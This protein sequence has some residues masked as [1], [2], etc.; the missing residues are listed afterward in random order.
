[1]NKKKITRLMAVGM[2]LST[3]SSIL[4]IEAVKAVEDLNSHSS[5]V[6]DIKGSGKSD[7]SIKAIS[8]TFDNSNEG[9][10]YDDAW[11]YAS[12]V[13]NVKHN[14][15]LEALS[16]G[17]D[18]SQNSQT[19]WSEFKISNKLSEVKSLNGYNILT[20]DFIYDS[21]SMSS[22]GFKTKLFIK[23]INEENKN[24]DP[25]TDIKLSEAEKL[26]NGLSK[27]SVKI[28]FN[29]KDISFD[30][31]TLGIIGVNTNYK[32][33]LYIDNIV[34]DKA[35][36][37]EIYV[38]KTKEPNG[39]Q[40]KVKIDDLEMPEKVKLVDSKANE[41]TADLYAYLMAL[42]KSDKV[43]YGHQNDT[44]RKATYTEGTESDTKD[45][46]GSISGVVGIDTLSLTGDELTS[47]QK[48]DEKSYIQKC[49]EIGK[50]TA[51]QGGI[52]TL[53]AHMPNLAV[54]KDK[55]KN[56][57]GKYDYSGY[58]SSTTQGNV[59]DNMLPGGEL[60]EVYRGFLDIIAEYAHGLGDTPI[61]FRPL[62][63][64]NGSWFWWG[65]AF[66]DSQTYKSVFAYTVEY[67]RDVKGVHN[68]L[69]VYSPNGPFEDED[70]YLSRYPGDEFVDVIAFDMYHE[71]PSSAGTDD[72]WFESL[73]ETV[74]LVDSVAE[75]RGK[76]S[77]ASELGVKAN[78]G[79]L[80][81]SDN[82]NKQ[83]FK[84][85]SDILSES[86]MPYYMTWANFNTSDNFFAPF[87]V[88]ETKGHEMINDFIDY[89][90]DEKSIFANQIGDYTQAETKVDEAYS[91]GYI[92][93]PVSRQRILKPTTIKAKV[94]NIEGNVSFVIKDKEGKVLETISAQEVD[95]IWTGEITKDILN[96]IG[97]VNGTIELK[98][99]DI[100]L[101]YIK[102][103][104]NMKESEKEPR[105]VDDFEQY[106]G[107]DS[108]ISSEW[109]PN[110]G[111]G[112]AVK[113]KLSTEYKKDGEYGLEFAYKISTEKT[114]EGYTGIAKSVGSNWS[115]TDALQLWIKPDGNGQ[116]LIIQITS[117]GEEFEVNLQ[118]IA[119]TT[120][121]QLLKIDFSRFKGKKGGQ[122]DLSNIEKFAI[123]CNTIV[124]DGHEGAW[125]VNSSIYFDDIRAI[126]TKETPSNGG[127]SSSGEGSSSGSNNGNNKLE[128]NTT[129][130]KGWILENGK[131]YYI[132]EDGTK[133]TGWLKD[134]DGKWYYLESNGEMK[135]GWLKDTNGKWYYLESNGE[136]KTGWLKDSD[137][138]W[139]YLDKN[140]VMLTNTVVDGFV[141]DKNGVWIK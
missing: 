22:G 122:L 121:P 109:A 124:P 66:C 9:W 27:V 42:G 38:E 8:W 3:S 117:N 133:K 35:P 94:E 43:I 57:D 83:W 129:N 12:G 141:L 89:Y 47:A 1:M 33:T 46:T 82:L 111:P 48:S 110:V 16:L 127:G 50:Q 44:H 135:T 49:I 137:G 51:A 114:T 67:L 5:Y 70:D 80:A 62:H 119:A 40:S 18:Y 23:D 68:F 41:N 71:N 54:V 45:I 79:G 64:N 140:G 19:S 25:Y 112:C 34:L 36:E 63:E 14:S 138:K 88:D 11:D 132:Q 17:V 134:V 59:V 139:Y 92:M 120:E 78:G 61:L 58:S 90:N 60:N 32:G 131:W 97:E 53:S 26:D 81:L 85:V 2:V 28:E 73:R 39:N 104:F 136:M 96:K 74:K 108:L 30:E 76:L 7:L 106:M 130:K 13:H 65:G 118:D 10:N 95:G 99:G 103:L 91:Y 84:T 29:T 52:L 56:E 128:D 107:D 93:S 15:E 115:G 98:C 31:I 87:M 21:Q 125:T 69:Y 105:V 55:G 20:Y 72:P 116:K 4:N 37:K 75:K 113:P 77:A 102:A 24:I 123:Y 100:T 6:N 101:N 126:N 86:N